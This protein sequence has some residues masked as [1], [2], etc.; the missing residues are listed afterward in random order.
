MKSC[1]HQ[2]MTN[3]IP[4]KEPAPALWLLHLHVPVSSLVD[5]QLVVTDLCGCVV[6]VCVLVLVF[7]VMVQGFYVYP[8]KAG[9]LLGCHISRQ[10]KSWELATG[11]KSLMQSYF[12]NLIDYQL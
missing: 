1:D 6:C 5:T 7:S 3:E 10:S 12:I 4:T 11:Y 2:C 8:S 9:Q